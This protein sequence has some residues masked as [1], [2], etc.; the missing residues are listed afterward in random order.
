MARESIFK[1]P[2]LE[3]RFHENGKTTGLWIAKARVQDYYDHTIAKNG[4]HTI[5]KETHLSVNRLANLA[6]L[7][8]RKNSQ[9]SNFEF[10][11][12]KQKYFNTKGGGVS[13]FVLTTQV[14]QQAAWTPEVLVARQ[15]ELINRLK[16]VWQL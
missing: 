5:T 16:T 9:A 2:K 14:L 15:E 10:D 1:R 8:Q 11:E 13:P 3:I 6:L 12:K 7:T 4:P